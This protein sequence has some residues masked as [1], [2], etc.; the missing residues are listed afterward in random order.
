MGKMVTDGKKA[1]GVYRV[2]NRKRPAI[3][4]KNGNEV[5]VYGYFTNEKAADDFMEALAEFFGIPDK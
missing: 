1:I 3:A 4:I 2:P 5:Y